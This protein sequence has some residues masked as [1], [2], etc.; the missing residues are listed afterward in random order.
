MCGIW[1]LL[2]PSLPETAEA[3]EYVKKLSPRGPEQY[4][5]SRENH[6]FLG[7]TRLAINGCNPGGMQ[8]FY[9]EKL[10]WMCNGEIYNA[11]ELAK[12][13]KIEMPSGSD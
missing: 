5:V 4:R 8:P 10:R 2:G 12:Q 13:Y 3:R 1:A 11:H 6:G 9:L 7:F